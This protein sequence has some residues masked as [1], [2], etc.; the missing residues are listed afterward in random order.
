M[1]NTL[2]LFVLAFSFI[3]LFGFANTSNATLYWQYACFE[4]GAGEK[5]C[6]WF[7]LPLGFS[8]QVGD[9]CSNI[10]VSPGGELVN[11]SI[12]VTDGE[13]NGVIDLTRE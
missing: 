8:N 7:C 1:K 4:N 6:G 2:K 10:A 12:G 13:G 3:A 5:D 9:K 11:S